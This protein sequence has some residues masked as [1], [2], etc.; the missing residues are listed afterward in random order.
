MNNRINFSKKRQAILDTLCETRV[1][2]SA[3]WIHGALR[4]NF[5]SISLGTVYRNLLR[6]KAEGTVLTLAVVDGQER[7]EGN[8]AEHAHFICDN[9]GGIFDL[10]IPLPDDIGAKV[11]QDGYH[12]V[13]RQLFLRGCCPACAAKEQ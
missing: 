3:E 1:H 8:T 9:C 4:P 11:E 13:R 6:F 5:P 2:P 7:F 12:L 10:D